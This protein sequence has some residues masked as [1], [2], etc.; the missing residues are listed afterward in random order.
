MVSEK[1]II[2]LITLAILMSVASIIITVSSINTNMIPQLPPPKE[3]V[4]PD[5]ATAKV[6]MIIHT[7]A[8]VPTG[9]A[10]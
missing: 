10:P 5:T 7:P 4:V 2:V 3:V 1:L 8:P 6:G 9:G